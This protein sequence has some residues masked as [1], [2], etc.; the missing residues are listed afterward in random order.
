M[1]LD[2]VDAS[3]SAT[4]TI[5][6]SLE[7]QDQLVTEAVL[8][9]AEPEVGGDGSHS[10]MEVDPVDASVSATVSFLNHLNMKTTSLYS[11]N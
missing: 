8:H 10:A 3:V 5:P 4:V 6:G 1:E 2:V 11:G 7:N 9:P